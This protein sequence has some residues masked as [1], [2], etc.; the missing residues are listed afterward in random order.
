MF[1]YST[2]S[3]VIGDGE[4]MMKDKFYVRVLEQLQSTD[5]N[6]LE[7]LDDLWK[8]YKINNGWNNSP[9]ISKYKN[10]SSQIPVKQESTMDVDEDN[11]EDDEELIQEEIVEDDPSV[12]DSAD[13]ENSLL[14]KR[15]NA[16]GTTAPHK[17][18]RI[19]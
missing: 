12:E 11:E 19:L 2:V 4:K 15:Q 10:L 14:T 17:R 3:F 8:K 9:D 1:C 16:P 7:A 5:P 13:H 6:S 18:A